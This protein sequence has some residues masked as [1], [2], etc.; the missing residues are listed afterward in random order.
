MHE[1]NTAQ[2]KMMSIFPIRSPS[3]KKARV[4]TIIGARLQTMPT[5]ETLKYLILWKDIIW[6]IPPETQR[7]IKAGMLLR[8]I[9][10]TSSSFAFLFIQSKSITIE[11]KPRTKMSSRTPKLGVW[12][13]CSLLRVFAITMKIVDMI[14]KNMPLFLLSSGAASI[15]SDVIFCNTSRFGSLDN[16]SSLTLINI[17]SS[18]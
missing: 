17:S 1:Q 2:K 15:I 18:F 6:T 3:M 5:V 9:L 7:K 13:N 16:V 11:T 14:M 8:S 4:Q 10:S 12:I